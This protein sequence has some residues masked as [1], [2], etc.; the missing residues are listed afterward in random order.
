MSHQEW[1]RGVPGLFVG[2]DISAEPRGYQEPSESPSFPPDFL[3]QQNHEPGSHFGWNCFRWNCFRQREG[4]GVCW[5][6]CPAQLGAL[7]GPAANTP[8]HRALTA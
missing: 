8:F 3:Q 4:G 6:H 7:P 1:H 5:G 2:S